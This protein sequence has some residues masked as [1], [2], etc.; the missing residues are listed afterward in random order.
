M[1]RK[2]DRLLTTFFVLLL[3]PLF[4][5]AAELR[6]TSP[7][8]VG[9]SAERLERLDAAL[10][11]YVENDQIAGQVVIVLRDGRVVFSD[12]N[13]WR[14]KEAGVAMTEDTI[15]RI[16]SQTK[17]IVSTGIMILHERGKLDINH[18]LSRY[19]PCLLYTSPS[20]RDRG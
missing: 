11:S 17:A 3:F 13:G 20:P 1:K 16:A 9:M 6:N 18:P 5:T 10:S 19:F 12:A 4:V 15:F 2:T 14:D 8:R 7:E